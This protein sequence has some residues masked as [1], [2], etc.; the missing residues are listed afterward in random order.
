M[1]S[2]ETR[3]A[4]RR[5]R[6]PAA[7]R[8]ERQAERIAKVVH[9]VEAASAKVARRAA[10]LEEELGQQ[11]AQ[12][13]L[14][15]RPEPGA[16]RPRLSRD[17]IARVAV[18]IADTEGFD[19]LS[20]RRIAAALGAGTMT[21]YYYVRTKDELLALVRDAV[22]A[23]L[24]VPEDELATDWRTAIT[25]I[26][27]RSRDALRRHPWSLEIREEHGPSPN[28]TRHFDQ[29]LQALQDLDV[30]LADKF[31]LIT[32]VDEYV[33]GFCFMEQTSAED[34][35]ATAPAM[36]RYVEALVATGD[37]P[38]LAAIAATHGVVGA[39]EEIRRRY[40][41]PE[42]FSRNLARLLDGFAASF[43]RA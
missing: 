25:R 1:A 15:T 6:S 14:W 11:L 28:A 4:R 41:D 7:R 2:D 31:E 17:E 18:Q 23:E 9:K 10:E 38:A 5:P 29:C 27:H 37:Y 40:A 22:M 32:A 36:L 16:R 21:L 43:G 3:D 34:L 12:Y 24:L 8:A 42:R 30:P 13:D 26:A 20:M 35:E 33:F 39:F 19:A